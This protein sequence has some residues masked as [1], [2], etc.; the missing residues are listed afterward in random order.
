MRQ[1]RAVLVEGQLHAI[2]GRPLSIPSPNRVH[3]LDESF[4][5]LSQGGKEEPPPVV[6]FRPTRAIPGREDS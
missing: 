4:L 5:P 3:P 6:A 2:P 1:A